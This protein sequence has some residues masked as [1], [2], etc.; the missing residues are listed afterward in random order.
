MAT[1]TVKQA[2]WNT[3]NVLW[4]TAGT[5]S[6][7]YSA[8][9]ISTYSNISFTYPTFLNSGTTAKGCALT[10]YLYGSVETT[11]KWPAD[12]AYTPVICDSVTTTP[13]MCSFNIFTASVAN[14]IKADVVANYFYYNDWGAG[15]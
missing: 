6:K 7:A 4:K 1:C 2:T 12:F 11:Y 9:P 14:S 3:P 15:S 5:V 13:R 10:F 8:V